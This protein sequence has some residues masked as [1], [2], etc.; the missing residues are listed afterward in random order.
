M[1]SEEAIRGTGGLTESDI[2][3]N[4]RRATNEFSVSIKT[5]YANITVMRKTASHTPG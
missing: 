3:I 5:V 2:I 4:T 1:T